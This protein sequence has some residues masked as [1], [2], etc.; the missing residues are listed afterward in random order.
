[1]AVWM[2]V[3]EQRTHIGRNID[4]FIDWLIDYWAC[5]GYH[6]LDTKSNVV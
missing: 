6:I 4:V 1:M 3:G 5:I 2:E